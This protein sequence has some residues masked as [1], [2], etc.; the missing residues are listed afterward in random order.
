LSCLCQFSVDILEIDRSFV[1]MID[2]SDGTPRGLIEPARTLGQEI[3]AE[4][5]ETERLR[6]ECCEFAQGTC[7]RSGGSR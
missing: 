6:D 1:A 2:A 7:T 3:V 4:G 5:V